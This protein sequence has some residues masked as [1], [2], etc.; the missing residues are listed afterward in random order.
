MGGYVQHTDAARMS[1]AS[2]MRADPA[3]S[4]TSSSYASPPNGSAG[5]QPL[6]QLRRALNATPRMQHQHALQRMLHRG[7]ERVNETGRAAQP[8]SSAPSIIQRKP[9]KDADTGLWHDDLFPSLKL[10]Q[11]EDLMK[12]NSSWAMAKS[13]G[14]RT[15]NIIWIRIAK[16][17]I[18]RRPSYHPI[19]LT[20]FP[21]PRRAPLSS[22]CPTC[23]PASIPTARH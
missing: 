3:P 13:S 16:H 19:E 1:H 10:T 22:V 18:S 4:A 2:A 11:P 7:S 17:S 9:R 21:W 14:G 6:L 20:T 12:N 15:T 8:V 5:M 23:C